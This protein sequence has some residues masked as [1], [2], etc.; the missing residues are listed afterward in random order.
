[1]F[2]PDLPGVYQM[3]DERGAVIYV[4]KAKSLKHRLRSYFQAGAV[5]EAKV[6]VMMQKVRDFEYIITDTEREALVLESNMIKELRPHYNIR[7]KDDKHYPYLRLSVNEAYPRL[8]VVRRVEKDGARYFGPYPHSGVIRDLQK[9]LKRIFPLR[10]CNREVAF[11]V[12]AGRPC[13]HFHLKQ[14]LGPCLGTVTTSEYGQI[15][16][17][18]E[19][20]LE[21]KH[22]ALLTGLKLQMEQEAQTLNFERA[23][24]LRDQMRAIQ[25]IVERQKF[26]AAELL[27]RDVVGVAQSLDEACVALFHMREG[28]VV[29]RQTVFLTGT[30]D[31]SKGEILSAFLAQ[32]YSF[33]PS[34]PREIVLDDTPVDMLDLEQVLS[35]RRGS[36]AT[37][38]VPKRGAKKALTALA[39]R[40]ALQVLEER[41][42]QVNGKNE[43]A[44]RGLIELAHY[45]GLPSPP[46]RVECYDISNIQGTLSVGSMV[47]FNAGLPGKREYRRFRI[48]WVEGAND[49]ASLHE[50]LTRRLAAH[51]A[52]DAKFALLPDLIIVDG[53]RG[54]L[55]AALD[56]LRQE[57]YEQ[58]NAVSLAKSEEL[59]FLP[60]RAEPVALPRDSQARYLVQRIRD[61]AHRFAVSFHRQ[62][63]QKT[64]RASQLEACPGIGPARRQ[65]LLKHFGGIEKMRRSSVE[66]LAA[67]KGMTQAVAERLAATLRLN[68]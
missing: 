11:G 52:G 25:A 3:I 8:S 1:M 46:E 35:R 36:K 58:L 43:L 7:I 2:V 5:Q 16:K 44:R 21:G 9:L 15:V 19:L 30:A 23:A 32:F 22:D 13:L 17:R 45:L 64:A 61:E 40:N 26:D 29:S 41:W 59:L 57:G 31:Q 20:L 67:V 47:V 39:S 18:L 53:G 48:R 62:L 55:N 51:R 37:L 49:F 4:G 63:R 27:D 34:I 12:S 10:T 28:K 24:F 68:S 60:Y 65:A 6:R 54:Q 66:E 33:G 38:V 56:A 50:V 42:H 14:C